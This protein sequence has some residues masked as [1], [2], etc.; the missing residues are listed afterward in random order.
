[1]PALRISSRVS[2]SALG[3][4][5]RSQPKPRIL[6]ISPVMFGED[7]YWGGGERSPL[8]L[9]RAQSRLAPTRLLSFAKR[10]RR[11]LDG[12]LELRVLP[13]RARYRGNDLNPVSRALVGEIAGASIVHVHQ[14][15]TFLT[16]LTLIVAAALRRN[17]FV[18]DHGGWAPNLGRLIPRRQ[19][20]TRML[21]VS[22]YAAAL[23][24]DFVDR[25]SVIYGG[26]DPAR[27]TP[28]EGPRH[29]IVF[30]GRLL[31]HKGVDVLIEAADPDM[32]LEIYGRA[33]DRDYRRRLAEL[34][35]DKDVRFIDDADDA[36]IIRAYQ[37]ARVAVLPSVLRSRFGPSSVKAELFGL[38]QVEAMACATPVLCS[39]IGPLRETMTDGVTGFVV[40]PG[41]AAELRRRLRMLCH[42]DELWS[43]MSEAA[44]RRVR[45]NFT[46]DHA[47]RRALDAYA[48]TI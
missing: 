17:V 37:S 32:Q 40:P 7:G 36:R 44:L 12:Q 11:E 20:I 33:Y 19:L 39:D 27:F 9:A 34:A 15:H 22:H 26:V 41:D 4:K 43:R 10:P 28:R 46:W 5:A 3:R 25:T 16:D 13:L 29:A 8:E 47:A 23:F 2:M 18:T 21:A 42:D 45:D 48:S 38:T 30:V 14:F 35:R 31:P 6:H 24:P 1:M